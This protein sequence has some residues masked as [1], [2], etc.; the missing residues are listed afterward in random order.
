MFHSK[1]EN[2]KKQS[3]EIEKKEIKSKINFENY[4]LQ[5]LY[6][7]NNTFFQTFYAYKGI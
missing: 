5:Y 4:T 6:N 7:T 3:N 1:L 2:E